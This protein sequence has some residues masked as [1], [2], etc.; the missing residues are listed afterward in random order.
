MSVLR[1]AAA[2]SLALAFAPGFANA[3]SKPIT[4]LKAFIESKPALPGGC[5]LGRTEY[6]PA[7]RQGPI[8]IS[9]AFSFEV[10][11]GQGSRPANVRGP[12]NADGSSITYE[13][14]D[15][16][17]SGWSEQRRLFQLKITLSGNRV[18]SLSV[19]YSSEKKK[20]FGGT[21]WVAYDST[22]CK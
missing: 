11:K 6:R 14:V 1:A 16:A 7:G 13:N 19:T 17:G 15:M 3:A 9:E 10:V 12:V 20:L 4:W 8:A 22:V 21:K 18:T 2:V 5:K